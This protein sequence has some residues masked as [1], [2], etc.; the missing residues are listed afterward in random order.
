MAKT[1]LVPIKRNDKVE[2][3]LPYIEKVAKPGSRVIFLTS[4]PVGQWQTRLRDHRVTAESRDKA[5]LAGRQIME[6]YCWD[7]QRILAEQQLSP[8]RESLQRQ[9]V[10]TSVNL[11]TGSLRKV[12]GEYEADGDL[13]LLLTHSQNHN[14]VWRLWWKMVSPFWLVRRSAFSPVSMT[15]SGH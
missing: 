15:R 2:E 1:I 14:P 11:Y 13:F 5:M 3:F 8:C 6:R 7:T 9:G 12:L 4:Y 10:E